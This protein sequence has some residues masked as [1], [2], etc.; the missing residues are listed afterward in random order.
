MISL[1][2]GLKSAEE[3]QKIA[4]V[5]IGLPEDASPGAEIFEPLDPAALRDTLEQIIGGKVGCQVKLQGELSVDRACDSH[6][7][8][9]LNGESLPC[10]DPDGWRIID[11]RHIELVGAPC[12]QWLSEPSAMVHAR[13]P[14][15]VV[16]PL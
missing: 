16:R 4:N 9:E 8:V 6:G 14:C 3:L 12:D 15:A 7:F 1:A 2:E 5:G 10:D 13:F 11:E